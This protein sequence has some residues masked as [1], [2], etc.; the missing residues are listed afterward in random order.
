[1]KQFVDG[2]KYKGGF[3][4]I[5]AKTRPRLW[6]WQCG[7]ALYEAQKGSDLAPT[8][9]AAKQGAAINGCPLK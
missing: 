6:T 1:M 2:C 8:F 9:S 3:Y 4:S 5:M 7:N